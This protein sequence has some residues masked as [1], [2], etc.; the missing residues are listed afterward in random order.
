MTLEIRDPAGS[1]VSSGDGKTCT[2]F[3]LDIAQDGDYTIAVT[4]K[5]GG[6]SLIPNEPQKTNAY[7]FNNVGLGSYS[8][9]VRTINNTYSENGINELNTKTS[10]TVVLNAYTL[11][12]DLNGGTGTIAN[13]VSLEN[14]DLTITNVEPT[15]EDF[16]FLGWST[17]NSSTEA[18]YEKGSTIKLT[19]NVILYAV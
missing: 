4:A 19:G 6:G 15:R 1:A 9:K 12:Y 17:N 16:T 2:D 18:E 5:Q 14:T 7:T 8:L 11:S 13:Q 10:E 3:T